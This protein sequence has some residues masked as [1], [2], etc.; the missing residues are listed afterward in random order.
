LWAVQKNLEL[1]RNEE[2]R[3]DNE[4]TAKYAKLFIR[5]L[6][7]NKQMCSV[8]IESINELRERKYRVKDSG[9]SKFFSNPHTVRFA[10][11]ELKENLLFEYS[12]DVWTT[13]HRIYDE[14]DRLD[15]KIDHLDQIYRIPEEKIVTEREDIV[16]G[17]IA[18]YNKLIEDIDA[19]LNEL[20]K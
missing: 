8:K 4:T 19:L 18:G 3:K 1:N 7:I 6:M 14:L 15:R 20:G 10:Y 11:D 12:I 13:I 2:I 16:N 17:S 9:E 5:E